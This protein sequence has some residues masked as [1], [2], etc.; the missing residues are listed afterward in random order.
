MDK[1]APVPAKLL[2]FWM[3]WE[4]CDTSPGTVLKN[5]KSGGPRDVFEEMRS[6]QSP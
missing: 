3:E 2:A 1:P 6:P 4:R 5:V